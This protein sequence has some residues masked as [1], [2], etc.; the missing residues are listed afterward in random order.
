MKIVEEFGRTIRALRQ[1]KGLTQEELG[2]HAGLHIS[3][4]GSVERGERNLSLESIHKICHALDVPISE[5]FNII[6]KSPVIKEDFMS[7]VV[8]IS[9]EDLDFFRELMHKLLKWRDDCTR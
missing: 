6:E 9:H 2:E 5:V 7:Y 1:E 4:I 3:Y 8:N